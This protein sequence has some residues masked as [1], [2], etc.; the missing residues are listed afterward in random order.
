MLQHLTLSY[1]HGWLNLTFDCCRSKIGQTWTKYTIW[2]IFTICKF[3]HVKWW[4]KIF[5]GTKKLIFLQNKCYPPSYTKIK[6]RWFNRF[7]FTDMIISYAQS[8]S[9][10]V[11]LRNLYPDFF[12]SGR[13]FEENLNDSEKTC[14]I[15]TRFA[16]WKSKC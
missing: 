14:E 15:N 13:F 4:R 12:L 5:V 10:H 11:R 3:V 7:R 16:R 8:L 2:K 6:C 9:G 1:K